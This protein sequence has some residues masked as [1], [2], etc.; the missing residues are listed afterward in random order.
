MTTPIIIL[1]LLMGPLAVFWI[2]HRANLSISSQRQLA[3]YGLAL[4][5]GFF[6]LGHFVKTDGMVAMLP[7]LIPEAWR[8]ALVYLTGGLEFAIALLLLRHST[9]RMAAWTALPVFIGFFPAN[10]YAALN[11]TGLGGHNWGPV[12]LWIRGPLQLVLIAWT[13]AW[14]IRPGKEHRVRGQQSLS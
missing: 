10:V 9:R 4:A 8:Y 1:T 14:L 2:I 13:Y 11:Y 5:F 3:A 7:N 12:Y 6:A